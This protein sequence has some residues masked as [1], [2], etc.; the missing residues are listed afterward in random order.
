[1]AAL[2]SSLLSRNQ[3]PCRTT[4]EVSS[5][6]K[7]LWKTMYLIMKWVLLGLLA[8]CCVTRGQKSSLNEGGKLTKKL[9]QI[10]ERI[11]KLETSVGELN[12]RPFAGFARTFHHHQP[13]HG[14]YKTKYSILLN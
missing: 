1:M 11:D 10:N 13:L 6:V 9:V 14:A 4:V 8:F 2:Y 3:N 7:N 12:E 5:T